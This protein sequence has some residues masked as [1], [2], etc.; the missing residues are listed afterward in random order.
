MN[1]NKDRM[2]VKVE[3]KTNG[4]NKTLVKENGNK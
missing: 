1:E 3:G 4:L 2:K